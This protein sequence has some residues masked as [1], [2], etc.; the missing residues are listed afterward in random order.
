MSALPPAVAGTP[1]WIVLSSIFD[2]G[3]IPQSCAVVAESRLHD[4][5]ACFLARK[6]LCSNGTGD[7][8]CP[9]CNG[10][11]DAATHPD[12]I[13]SGA[14]GESPRIDRCRAMIA[15]LSLKPVVSMRRL[16]VFFGSD[17]MSQG[18]ANCLL[19]TL[20]E[21]PVYAHILL[22]LETNTLL[23]TLRSRCWF[24]VIPEEALSKSLAI[25]A[26]DPEWVE[27]IGKA[28]RGTVEDVASDVRDWC[29]SACEARNFPLA[30]R[31]ERLRIVFR[32][33]RLSLAMSIDAVILAIRE[34]VPC[35]QIFGSLR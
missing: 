34:E 10:W 19:K 24:Y 16:A 26:S 21:P 6:V 4:A 29:S 28:S 27:W 20:E 22:L 23:P 11:T 2:S 33:K 15:E 31:L 9:G 3:G 17:G 8:G 32:E 7:D 14:P 30:E 25:P 35:E 1:S 12:F 13:L 5:I 18:A